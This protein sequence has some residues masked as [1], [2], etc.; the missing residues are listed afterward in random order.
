MRR[1]AAL[2]AVWTLLVWA[3]RL[4][5]AGADAGAIALAAPFI[6]L[7]VAVLVGLWRARPWLRIAVTAL[8]AWTT[9]VWVVRGTLIWT[10]DHSIGFKV[11]HTVLAVVSI[12]LAAVAQ[13]HVQRQRQ[14][15]APAAGLQELADR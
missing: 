1:A 7:A 3:G 2:L 4:R 14:A 11:V 5:N 15:T 6:V 9:V 13:R 8:A 12:G 10:H